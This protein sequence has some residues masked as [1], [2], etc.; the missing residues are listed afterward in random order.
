MISALNY[1]KIQISII[2]YN[3]YTT[4]QACNGSELYGFSVCIICICLKY[5]WNNNLYD[6]ISKV[7]H[8]ICGLP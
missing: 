5:K 3:Y 8:M 7:K 2:Y 6:G 4:S 1:A